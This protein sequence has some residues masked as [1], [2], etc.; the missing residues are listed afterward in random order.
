MKRIPQRPVGRLEHGFYGLNDILGRRTVRLGDEP[1]LILAERDIRHVADERKRFALRNATDFVTQ[2]NE[3]R[4]VERVQD[5]PSNPVVVHDG[6]P[7]V[8]S[9]RP[10][11]HA[12][13]ERA[14]PGR[15][16]DAVR[17]TGN[18]VCT[19]E[20]GKEPDAVLA[21]QEVRR[22]RQLVPDDLLDP[23]RDFLDAPREGHE[24]ACAANRAD[25]RGDV[26]PEPTAR[27]SDRRRRVEVIARGP[28]RITFGRA[29]HRA[30]ISHETGRR[31]T[32]SAKYSL[33]PVA[34]LFR[35]RAR[36]SWV[37]DERAHVELGGIGQAEIGAFD[38]ALRAALAEDG[39][40]RRIEVNAHTRRVVFTF[41]R[42]SVPLSELVR[43]VG[44]AERAAGV[45]KARFEGSPE[46]PADEEPVLRALV[47][48]SADIA[49]FFTGLGLSLTPIPAFPFAG[50]AAAL[51]SLV[52]SVARLRSEIERRIGPERTELALDLGTAFFS[53]LAQRPL[54]SLVDGIHKAA[55]L[56]ER[57]SAATAWSRLE[58]SLA[59]SGTDGVVGAE[60]RE[61]R[62][63]PLP[64]GP[65]EDYAGRAWIVSLAG[66][67]VSF[68]TSRSLQRAIAALYGSLPRPA[69]I[70]R[71]IFSS[72]IGRILA[73]RDTLVLAPEVL[74]KL[75][76]IDCLVLQGDLVS[77]KAFALGSVHAR[78]DADAGAARAILPH[79]FAADQPL[80]RASRG[81]F[82][83]GPWKLAHTS[84]PQELEEKARSLSK[85]GALV[86][87]L[88]RGGEVIAVAEVMITARPGL[89][90]LVSAAHDAGMRVVMASSEDTILQAVSADDVISDAEGIRAGIRRLQR[91]G[92][93]VCLVATGDSLGL[94]IADLGVGLCRPG[95]PTPWGAHLLC[96][97]DLIEVRLLLRA[98]VRAREVSRQS[99]NIALGA[100]AF[101][102]LVSAG[103]LLPLTSRRVMFVV[104][105]ATLMS[106]ANGVRGSIAIRHLALP[107]SRDP[108]PWHA[109]DAEGV[110]G[111]LSST[112]QGLSRVDANLRK[113]AALQ[114][115]SQIRN[116]GE[117]ITEELF[118]PLAPLLA[119]GAGLSAAVGSIADAAMVGSVVGFNAFIGGVQRFSTEQKLQNLAR[120]DRR[121]AIVRREGHGETVDANVLV[122]GDVVLLC[123]GDY[124]PADCR[125]LE[126]SGLEVDASSLT[127]ES[128]PVKKFSAA[129]FE[130]EPADRSSMVYE[131]TTVVAGSATAV[132][133]AV[134][135]HTEARRGAAGSKG[136]RGPAG[137]ERK[138]SSL[139]SLTGPIA[140]AAG[141]SVIGG[142]LLRG[143]KLDDLV[144]TGVSLAV[145]SVPEGLPLLAT[146]A[147]LAASERLSKRH[148][149]VR[150]AR[151]IEALGRV[152]V[153]CLDKTGTIT[154]GSLVLAVVSD[155]VH[156]ATIDALGPTQRKV[157]AASL[158]ATLRETEGGRGD[159]TDLALRE[160]AA[161]ALVGPE[162]G[163]P[164]FRRVGELSIAL[165]RSYH[166]VLGRTDDGARLAVKGA[167]E[168]LLLS[169]TA[170]EHD[171]AIEP[172]DDAGRLQLIRETTELAS[173]GLR[174]LAVAD[175]A[176][177]S[178]AGISPEHVVDLTFRG[179]LAFRDPVR[180]SAK[181]AIDG[182]RRAG[183]RTVMITGD[184]PSTAE[185]IASELDLLEERSVVT[186]AELAGLSDEDL[187]RRIAKV[188]VF[189]RVTPS[190]K[191]RVVRALQRAG[192][193]VAMAGDG[194][195][196]AAA[197]RLADVGIA[198]GESSTQAARAAADIVVT[199]GR[200][201]TIVDA[202][203]EGRAMWASVRSAVSILM[204]GNLGEI[205]FTLIAGLLDGSPPLHARQLLLVNLLTDVAP[206]MAIALKP[207]EPRSFES[208]ARETPEAAL[209][210]PLHREIAT[211]AI[212]TAAGAGAAWAIGR[213]ITS[214]PKA[215]TIGL[216]ALVGTQLGQTLVSGGY[217]RPVVA[218]S[219][220]SASVLALLIQTPGVSHFFGCRPL[221]PISWTAA[222]GASV[223]ATALSSVVE[224]AVGR[225]G[226]AE[227]EPA[228][229]MPP[230]EPIGFLTT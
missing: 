72:Q 96:P 209:G 39:R 140:L 12:I 216:V 62:P 17:R 114:A 7:E 51:L 45:P 103:G 11:E 81:D 47:G 129:S 92:R 144:G 37:T 178:D 196:D 117:A 57:R 164:G 133:V 134:G 152:D 102:A 73:A 19:R 143:K 32:M 91:E 22:E 171:G 156:S 163:C 118:S 126:A 192:N 97:D 204:G 190:Q 95:L 89:D 147:Q 36:R 198:I 4:L 170:R 21:E 66:F 212:V 195:N 166:A 151:A 230:R 107:P 24:E 10:R 191:V 221:G 80:E 9:R 30:V 108:T 149:L 141:A 119:A 181:K 219:I 85:E 224:R 208:L 138:L 99:V 94:P 124:V 74:R 65:I 157:V 3:L 113:S 223:A 180:P 184:H 25:E 125:I 106:M 173:R 79:L 225:W 56:R 76:R 189:A 201:E 1:L 123:A 109:L 40:I 33:E 42:G 44:E 194:A 71:D 70:G 160:G 5:E 177:A 214:R 205:G 69:R 158:R 110:L 52:D 168:V 35:E 200:V 27:R 137:V 139:M 115:P 84:L 218:T 227:T 148:A 213:V 49:A 23:K 58:A 185:A 154:L 162:H 105:T 28:S 2:E 161:I 50:N 167:P 60:P 13:L 220:A 67:A 6:K 199:D 197:I 206:A 98:C 59:S 48:L 145:A 127:G 153:V 183:V 16:P 128:L 88:E 121:R 155:G 93:G 55:T 207:P 120:T 61:D 68:G 64:H 43:A 130:V 174:V 82:H 211:R 38:R 14:V 104:N 111:R 132:V 46:H 136:A 26:P 41:E 90:E 202:I 175:R 29:S 210:A 226:W 179:F 78:S 101:G 75:D 87:A 182:M 53:A 34:R 203:V 122:P 77:A 187:D 112:K 215:R 8:H 229:G 186:G 100:A 86:L 176:M 20:H 228:D 172:L 188:A 83:L 135:D 31:Q 54:T 165:G 142:G 193:V 63:A 18:Q 116:L 146:A 222:I 217:S 131:G 169:C 159:P 15:P 150:N